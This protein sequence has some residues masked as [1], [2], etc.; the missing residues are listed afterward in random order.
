MTDPR[1]RTPSGADAH[2]PPCASAHHGV[3]E[4]SG[5]ELLDLLAARSVRSFADRAVERATVAEL[6][7]VARR[8]GSARN[9]QPWRFVAVDDRATLQVLATCGAYAGHLATAPCAIVL[10]SPD[11]GRRDTEFDLGRVAQ[12]LTLAA[13]AAGLGSC[14]AT[15][16]PDPEIE[17]AAAV[18]RLESG[19]VP[20][21]AL[22]LGHPAPPPAAGRP[23]VPPGRLPTR[24]LLR[25]HGP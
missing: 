16:Y 3:R 5:G 25:W 20:R 14:L 21:H 24:E 11:D 10:L 12:S 15:F 9:R 19:R 8:T 7:E 18:L 13:T 17:R 22:S 23:A 1:P 4:R 6:V 2:V